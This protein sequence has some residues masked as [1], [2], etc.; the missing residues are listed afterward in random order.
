MDVF[1]AIEINSSGMS[2][3][4]KRLN[5]ISSNIANARTTRTEDGGPYR[6]RDVVFKE[7][8]LPE[9]D[10]NDAKEAPAVAVDKI[11]E[12]EDD[13]ILKYE[14][15]HPD[16]DENGYVEYPNISVVK[17]MVNMITSTKSYEANATSVRAA[18]DMAKKA[19]NIVT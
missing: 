14:P 3:E 15:S 9:L 13:S 2:A 16:A 18:K 11:L 1:S 12:N 5:I 6:R 4:R 17:E 7:V 8:M 10:K 19:L